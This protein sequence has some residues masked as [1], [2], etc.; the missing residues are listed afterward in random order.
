M[1]LYN[2]TIVYYNDIHSYIIGLT[3]K[4]KLYES[5]YIENYIDINNKF[6][7][8][9]AGDDE[10]ELLHNEHFRPTYTNKNLYSWRIVTKYDDIIISCDKL[11]K[12]SDNYKKISLDN[13]KKYYKLGNEVLDIDE[14][15]DL[16]EYR[17]LDGYRDYECSGYEL[18]TT[19]I[20]HIKLHDK[21]I[22]AFTKS[23][24]NY[25][26]NLCEFN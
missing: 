12:F 14:L 22:E 20:T 25:I 13:N 2:W 21:Y 19:Q 24:S 8:L 11:K 3:K 7:K 6:I 5:P 18:L 16:F 10:I 9:Q 15:K 23:G 17:C 26:L 4:G 1:K